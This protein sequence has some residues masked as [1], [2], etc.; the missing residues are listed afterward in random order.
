MRALG[1][2]SVCLLIGCAPGS[3]RTDAEPAPRSPSSPAA[4]APGRPA[5]NATSKPAA[6]VVVTGV[7]TQQRGETEICPGSSLGPCAGIHVRGALDERWLS[8]PDAVTVWRLT[9]SFDGSALVLDGP[10]EPTSYGQ[11]PS[12]RNPCSQYQDKVAGRSI[13]SNPDRHQSEKLQS[14]L[15]TFPERLAAQWWDAERQTMVVWVTGD[16]VPLQQ[17]FGQLAPSARVCFKGQARFS[18]RE[19]E[20][21]RARADAVLTRH[22]VKW[23]SS[24]I[25]VLTNQVVY[26]ADAIHSDTLAELTRDTHGAV[27]VLA[28]LESLATPLAE[29]PK[30]PPRGDV[31]LLTSPVRSGAS[32]QALGRFS[33]HYDAALRCVYLADAEGKRL[34]PVWPFGYFATSV[35]VQVFDFD[36]VPVAGGGAL[37]EFA[38]GHVDLQHVQ[39]QDTCGA[40]SAWIG[41]PQR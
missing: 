35:P 32:M 9:G 10:A 1:T 31:E 3:K 17:R 36:G 23:S 40:T 29:L 15:S 24:S 37:V 12:Y 25:D 11:R 41:H 16:A 6:R 27:R 7:L 13:E 18:E 22:Q 38:G 4:A 20:A 21:A 5:A 34:L 28:F 19:L 8:R 33:L 30:P 14:F 39:T 26:D 2:L